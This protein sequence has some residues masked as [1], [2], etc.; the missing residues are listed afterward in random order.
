MAKESALKDSDTI[1][2]EFSTPEKAA[3]SVKLKVRCCPVDRKKKIPSFL[4][5]WARRKL[6]NR[7]SS[8][9]TYLVDVTVDWCVITRWL[10][11]SRA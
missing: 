11:S 6:S 1:F 9:K 7:A 8:T 10:L 4:F 2:E 5:R 3:E